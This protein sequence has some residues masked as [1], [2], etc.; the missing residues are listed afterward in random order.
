MGS[1]FV[2]GMHGPSVV[3]ED[4]VDLVVGDVDVLRVFLGLAPCHVDV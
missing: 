4:A 1:D 2:E 3:V